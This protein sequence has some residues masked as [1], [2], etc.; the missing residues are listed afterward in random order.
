MKRSLFALTVA[1]WLGLLL[2]TACGGIPQEAQE[3][4]EIAG[5]PLCGNGQVDPLEQCDGGV[6]PYTCSEW[7]N[8]EDDGIGPR[9][10]PFCDRGGCDTGF[11]C[12]D[13]CQCEQAYQCGDGLVHATEAEVCEPVLCWTDAAG[14]EHCREDLCAFAPGTT[15]NPDTCRCEFDVPQPQPGPEPVCGNDLVEAGE[16]CDGGLPE[17]G[18]LGPFC[19][20]GGCPAPTYCNA[21]CTCGE[22]QSTCSDGIWQFEEGEECE[23]LVCPAGGDEA[24]CRANEGCSEDD[25]C[26][27]DT[28]TCGP[29]PFV[30]VGPLPEP[31]EQ[32]DLPYC[33]DGIINSGE[34]CDVGVGC[35]PGTACSA[36]CDRCVTSLGPGPSPV[37]GDGVC[38]GSENSATCAQ[39]CP[40]GAPTCGN[41]I[42]EAGEECDP[43]GADTCGT[44]EVCSANCTCEPGG[45][46]PVCGNEVCE[47]GET[48]GN[49]PQDCSIVVTSVCGN[50]TC[51]SGENTDNC[52]QDCGIVVNPFCGDGICNGNENSATC[53][54]DCDVEFETCG[55]NRCDPGEDIL[56]CPAD[57]VPLTGPGT[58]S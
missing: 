8:P 32:P 35:D 5:N 27:P 56:S 9:R 34:V 33:G 52:P 2:A 58:G 16:E 44:S 47:A 53:P 48:L 49:C 13:S 37:C 39:D 18:C 45:G 40:A 31:G 3:V 10:A 55:N 19:D 29:S 24:A 28:C 21:D 25:I 6:V 23:P 57:C 15:C 30:I 20:R 1:A 36:T 38:Q 51:E 4:L 42:L 22:P 11:Y 26:N 17:G 46:G 43:P 14:N 50:G 7:E 41:A 12:N 54:G